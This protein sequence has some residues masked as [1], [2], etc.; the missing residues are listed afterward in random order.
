MAIISDE[1]VFFNPGDLCQVKHDLTMKPIM[2][3]VEKLTRSIQNKDG[4][5]SSLFIGIKCRWFDDNMV[6]REA[7]FST[8]D[9]IHVD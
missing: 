3:V 7:V 4:E 8:K 9:L 6:L 1:K 5:K 2:Y